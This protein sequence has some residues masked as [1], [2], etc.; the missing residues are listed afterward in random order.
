MS[1][2]QFV[3]YLTQALYL[4]ISVIVIVTA[5]RRPT[6][7]RIDIAIF[8]GAIT[9]IFAESWVLRAFGVRAGPGLTALIQV[10]LMALPYLLVRLVSDFAT[11]PPLILRGAELGLVLSV[12]AILA[13][14]I[15]LPTVLVLLMV[16]YF[17]GLNVYVAVAF[18]RA[19]RTSSGVTR[20]RMQAVAAGSGFLGLSILLIGLGVVQQSTAREVLGLIE[21]LTALASGLS[22]FLG[23]A[24]PALLRRAWQEPE[25]RAF[26]GRAASLPR[27]HDT[28]SIV[29]ELER[30]AEEAV[31]AP[32]AT[33][34]LWDEDTLQ[35]IYMGRGGPTPYAPDRLIAGRAFTT[36]QAVFSANAPRDDPQHAAI[37]RAS[38]ATAIL[39]APITAGGKRLGVLSV[40]APRAP[41]FAEED[42][43]L[44]QLLADQGAVILE[45]RAL[46]DEAARVQAREEATRL[47][48]DFLSAAAHDLKTPLTAL[49]ATAQLMERRALRQP[50]RPADLGAIRR[51]VGESSRLRTIVV[52]LLD[53]ARVEQRRLLG[54][55]GP[56][57]L[58]DLAREVG[59]RYVSAEHQVAVEAHE[60]VVGHYDR[61][62][63]AQL[64]ENLVENAV[65]YSPAGG[66]VCVKVWA[67]DATAYLTVTD[68]GIGIPSADL[69]YLFERFHRG[70][71]VNDRQ[72]AG[73]GLG[74]YICQGIVEE[75]GGRIEVSSVPGEGSTFRVSLP[76]QQAGDEVPQQGE[77]G[78]RVESEQRV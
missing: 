1:A 52:E 39:A 8:F 10:L 72:F 17:F 64:L 28:R 14:Q 59:A 75:H 73:M 48:D 37:Y 34:G 15:D 38:G 78:E 42:L 66:E 43:R 29:Q 7:A 46:I 26:L 23:F 74:L 60:P 22:F 6:R 69:P 4:L 25:L 2:S 11:V 63:L 67:E 35:L 20:R 71:N 50:E 68:Q 56:V 70:A 76:H 31:G 30:G 51:I 32:H 41:I 61:A 58:A 27:L 62:R 57:D 19:A 65:K 5:A 49:I 40:F 16:L 13:F 9:L 24:P 77:T 47:K 21:Q 44:V 45:S 36:Q 3:Q 33:I 54:T 12:I 18:L 55:R 53:A